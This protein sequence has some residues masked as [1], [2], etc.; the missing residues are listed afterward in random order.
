M[1]KGFY[2][3]TSAMLTHG[4]MLDVSSNNIANVSTAGFKTDQF[5]ASTFQEVMWQITGNRIKNYQDIGEQSFITAPRQ[6]YTD[7]TQG[8]LDHTGVLLDF[9]ING[10]GWFAIER[11]SVEVNEETGAEEENI[12]R[13]YTRGGSF[14]LD[15]EGYLYLA[16]QGRVL[17]AQE[18]PIQLGTD[19]LSP[20]NYGGLYTDN[21]AFRGR[22]GVFVF[23]NENGDVANEE[24]LEKNEQGLFTANEDAEPRVEAAQVLNGWVERSNMDWVREM[25]RMLSTQRAYQSAAEVIKIYDNILTRVTQ[26]AGR[27]T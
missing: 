2:N 21:G 4:R 23:R 10:P 5:T 3:L 16:G 14:M 12:E 24:N 9:A 27:L 13:V 8:S 11:R 18:E 7:F 20:D 25:T 1:T 17:S 19:R 6:M 22:I 15:D 26:E